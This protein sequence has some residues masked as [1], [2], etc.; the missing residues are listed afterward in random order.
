M[1]VF[2]MMTGLVLLILMIPAVYRIY[3]GPT[4]IDRAMGVNVIGT[5]TA[6]LLVVIGAVFERID[7]F[8]DFALAYGLLNFISSV[9]VARYLHSNRED[10]LAESLARGREDVP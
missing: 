6:V 8:V 3:A 9:A 10:T 2:F 1:M 7:M 4:A 5:K